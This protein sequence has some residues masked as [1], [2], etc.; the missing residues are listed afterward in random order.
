MRRQWI[1][2]SKAAND[3]RIPGVVSEEASSMQTASQWGWVWRRRLWRVSGRVSAALWQ[4]MTT[5]RSA[6][7]VAKPKWRVSGAGV[8]S[9][10]GMGWSPFVLGLASVV[11]SRVEGSDLLR[12]NS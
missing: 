8:G 1:L 7:G 11:A 6:V 12:R 2:G 9:C 3:L 10:V 4:G 5:E